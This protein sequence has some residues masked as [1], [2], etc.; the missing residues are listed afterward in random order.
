MG[1]TKGSGK[2]WIKISVMLFLILLVAGGAY[3]GYL[4]N[5]TSHMMDDSHEEA[6][7][8]DGHSAMRDE[9][10]DP[11][12]DNVSILFLGVDTGETRAFEEESRTDAILLATFNKDQGSVKLLSIPRDTY[13]YIPEVDYHTKINHAHYHG[14]PRAAMESVESYLNV[15]IDYYV[16]LNFDAF[17]DVVD[18]LDGITYNVPFE[19]NEMDSADKKDAIQLKPG[20][21]TLNGEEALALV[22]TRKYD[23]DLERG[24]RQQE[25]IVTIADKATSASSLFKLNELIDAVGTNIRTNLSFNQM[26]SFF[27]YGLNQDF[28]IEKINLDGDGGYMDDGL[29]YFHADATS[30]ANVQRELRTHLDLPAYTSEDSYEEDSSELNNVNG[31]NDSLLIENSRMQED[32]LYH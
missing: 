22:R 19:M 31:S 12:T 18:S 29:W 24:A 1:M 32:I 5:K 14:G 26:K 10:V 3:G 15:P 17:V 28:D 8:N 4:Y 25:V 2:K 21:Q 20:Y 6:G 13:A 7:R 16:R 30:L 23:N 27:S 9:A 11:V